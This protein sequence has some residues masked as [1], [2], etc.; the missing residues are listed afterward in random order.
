MKPGRPSNVPLSRGA[1]T[2][3]DDVQVLGDGCG[4]VFSAPRVEERISDMAFTQ[5]LRRLDPDFV[6]HGLCTNPRDWAAEQINARHDM[7]EA[8]PAHSIGNATGNGQLQRRRL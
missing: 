5:I 6:P 3:P 8:A 1:L 4:L 7:A 2:V